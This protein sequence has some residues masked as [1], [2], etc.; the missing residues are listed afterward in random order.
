MR[1]ALITQLQKKAFPVQ[2]S[3]RV[4]AVSC[5]GYYSAQSRP[6]TPLLCKVGVH[7]NVAFG[8]SQQ[9]YGSS[10]RHPPPVAQTRSVA[11][12]RDGF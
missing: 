10:A 6:A 1:H 11:K 4:L 3:C 2:Q 9:S 12:D 5:A 7:L 8:A